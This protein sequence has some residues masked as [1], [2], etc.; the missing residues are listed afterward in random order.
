VNVV[1]EQHDMRAPCTCGHTQGRVIL[2]ASQHTVRCL[3]CDR[4]CYNAPRSELGLPI[5]IDGI[6]PFGKH[7]GA[8]W[9]SIAAVDPSWLEWASKNLTSN[10]LRQLARAALNS[11][12]KPEPTHRGEV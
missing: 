1:K 9:R 10:G 8:T 5:D 11:E 12:I 7:K 6:V 2:V 3:S 4:F